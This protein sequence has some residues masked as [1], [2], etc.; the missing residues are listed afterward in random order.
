MGLEIYKNISKKIQEYRKIDMERAYSN[1][2]TPLILGLVVAGVLGSVLWDYEKKVD[3]N[4]IPI[5]ISLLTM[6]ISTFAGFAY[7][8]WR[9]SVCGRKSELDVIQKKSTDILNQ[10]EKIKPCSPLITHHSLLSGKYTDVLF[11]IINK[12]VQDGGGIIL[13]AG[14]REYLHYLE[15]ILDLSKETFFATLRGG[16]KSPK[17]KLSWF[18]ESDSLSDPHGLDADKKQQ[19]LKNV[20]SHPINMRN[21]VRLLIFNPTESEFLT[22]FANVNYRNMFFDLNTDV[23]VLLVSPEDLEAKLQNKGITPVMAGFIYEDYAVFDGEI[24]LKH[25][26]KTS[27]YVATKEQINSFKAVFDLIAEE[28]AIFIVL[29]KDKIGSQTWAEWKSSINVPPTSTL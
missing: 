18:F 21:K 26:S 14:P 2:K 10:L 24:V 7:L 5:L 27:L 4:I 3:Q 29:N 17:F 28:P 12:S 23:T 25:N 19:Y 6:L 13:S 16:K 15:Q 9:H 1:L 22:D 20:N 8:E 11:D